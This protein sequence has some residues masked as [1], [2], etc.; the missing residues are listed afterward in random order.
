MLGLSFP[1]AKANGYQGLSALT[2]SRT[3]KSM[4]MHACLV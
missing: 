4:P 1:A 2:A 3:K